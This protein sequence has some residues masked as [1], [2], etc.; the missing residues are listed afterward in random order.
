VQEHQL[1]GLAVPAATLAAIRACRADVWLTPRDTEPFAGPNRYPAMARAPLFPDAFRRAFSESYVR[2]G[3]T[4]F[5]DV[6]RCRARLQ[7]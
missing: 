4:Q 2:E 3:R 7:P 1:S 5:Y 6:W